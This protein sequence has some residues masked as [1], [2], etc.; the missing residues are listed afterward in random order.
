MLRFCLTQQQSPAQTINLVER[1]LESDIK[2][3][4]P[5]TLSLGGDCGSCAFLEDN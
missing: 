2:Y 5:P 4:H 3:L 1:T